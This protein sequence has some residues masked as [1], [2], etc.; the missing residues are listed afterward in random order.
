M[1]S[2]SRYFVDGESSSIHDNAIKSVDSSTEFLVQT[3]IRC[4]SSYDL[5]GWSGN[6]VCCGDV[7]RLGGDVLKASRTPMPKTNAPPIASHR[8]MARQIVTFGPGDVGVSIRY[9]SSPPEL[10]TTNS[11]NRATSPG[12]TPSRKEFL[13]SARSPRSQAKRLC[14]KTRYQRVTPVAAVCA[15]EVSKSCLRIRLRQTKQRSH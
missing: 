3:R 9:S 10:T 7:P 6:G 1:R 2:L 5:N 8:N 15:D 4:G 11:N 12:G 13:F 14:L